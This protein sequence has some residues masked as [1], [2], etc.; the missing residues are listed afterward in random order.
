MSAAKRGESNIEINIIWASRPQR[1]AAY[2]TQTVRD[3]LLVYA[4]TTAFPTDALHIE[5]QF[6][7]MAGL[8][9]TRHAPLHH[10]IGIRP[11][12]HLLVR[13]IVVYPTTVVVA[14]D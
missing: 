11:A 3:D 13:D 2:Y 8:R 1:T 6:P 12:L 5:N 14:C 9:G 10:Q 7:N 4:S